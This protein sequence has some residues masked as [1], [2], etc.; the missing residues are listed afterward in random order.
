[1]CNINTYR[2]NMPYLTLTLI[3]TVPGGTLDL[4]ITRLLLPL[5]NYTSRH[6]SCSPPSSIPQHIHYISPSCFWMVSLHF[7]FWCPIKCYST[8]VPLVLP[9]DMPSP[10]CS[11]HLYSA[12]HPPSYFWT[13][14]GRSFSLLVLQH[15]HLSDPSLGHALSSSSSSISPPQ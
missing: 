10:L 2:I 11:R 8:V 13:V 5:C 1:M 9:Q 4:N 14:P 6:V 3:L 7:P 12:S 15:S